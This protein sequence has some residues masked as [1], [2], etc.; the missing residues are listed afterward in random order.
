MPAPPPVWFP[1]AS[2]RRPAVL[3]C[4]ST[5]DGLPGIKDGASKPTSRCRSR[6]AI[7]RGMSCWDPR[8]MRTSPV[9]GGGEQRGHPGRAGG[10]TA[11]GLGK[12]RRRR[13]RCS[14]THNAGQREPTRPCAD[15]V[16]EAGAAP[17][18]CTYQPARTRESI[19]NQIAPGPWCPRPEPASRQAGWTNHERATAFAGRRDTLAGASPGK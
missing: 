11:C 1:R 18:R 15:A 13:W 3:A 4:R 12:L 14:A 2:E 9:I 19:T 16:H 5:A 7:S 10:R 17:A 6:H 8:R